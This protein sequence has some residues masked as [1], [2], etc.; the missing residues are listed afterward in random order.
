MMLLASRR[1]KRANALV[2]ASRSVAALLKAVPARPLIVHPDGSLET[3]SLLQRDLGL[4][5]MPTNLDDLA[6]EGVVA[7]HAVNP[8]G[9]AYS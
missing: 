6:V 9:A 4:P 7:I 3:D 1:I 5:T 2:A 8:S